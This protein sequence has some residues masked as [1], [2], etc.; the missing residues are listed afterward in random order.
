MTEASHGGGNEPRMPPLN[1]IKKLRSD[2]NGR[3]FLAQIVRANRHSSQGIDQTLAKERLRSFALRSLKRVQDGQIVKTR[4][5]IDIERSFANPILAPEWDTYLHLDE[6]RIRS[7]EPLV[8]VMTWNVFMQFVLPP[9]LTEEALSIP[10]EGL[11]EFVSDLS[12]PQFDETT[13]IGIVPKRSLNLLW[14]TTLED[15][16]KVAP[17]AAGNGPIPSAEANAL[18]NYLGLGHR[19]PEPRG[20]VLIVFRA[21]TLVNHLRNGEKVSR[22]FAFEGIG[23]QRFHLFPEDMQA[24]EDGW[25]RALD[26]AG[27]AGGRLQPGAREV[28]MT[29]LAATDIERCIKTEG[30]GMPPCAEKEDLILKAMLDDT[31]TMDQIEQEFRQLVE[32]GND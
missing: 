29:S 31:C 25:N 14:A 19:G 13:R 1:E 23:N 15:V 6:T 26:L 10:K 12:G 7:E 32:T 30:I 28:V 9:K 18:R 27:A 4:G 8:H 20:L 3:I 11:A 21:G 5:K 16:L 24:R 2:P 17:S 22:P